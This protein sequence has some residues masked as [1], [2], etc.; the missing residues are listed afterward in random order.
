MPNPFPRTWPPIED[1]LL[2]PIMKKLASTD[3]ETF[4]DI[5]ELHEKRPAGHGLQ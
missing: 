3:K 1:L 4:R 2:I 5:F